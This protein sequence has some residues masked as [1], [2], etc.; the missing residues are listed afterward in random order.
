VGC[1][2]ASPCSNTPVG[3]VS[4]SAGNG[5]PGFVT[6]E[7]RDTGRGIPAA[8]L[9]NVFERFYRADP[10]RARAGGR[11]GLGLAIVK[12][13]VELQGG[14]V[15]IASEVG[16]GTSVRFTLPAAWAGSR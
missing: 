8:D 11:T 6:F 4:V 3:V 16:L 9:P 12:Q 5:T 13:L 15:S 14:Q 1:G 2:S 10:T 7:V